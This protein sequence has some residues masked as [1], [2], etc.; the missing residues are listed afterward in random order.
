M[1]HRPFYIN[2]KLT[3]FQNKVL[4]RNLGI[5]PSTPNHVV[6]ALA[7]I[8]PT[9][10]RAQHLAEYFIKNPSSKTSIG[11]VYTKYQH[12]FDNIKIGNKICSSNKT[13]IKEDMF[14]VCKNEVSAE[15]LRAQYR[16]SINDL[17]AEG[18]SIWATDA[19]VS[20]SSTGCS[21]CN[22]YSGQNF[23]FRIEE[24]VSSLTGEL[25]AIEKAI[26]IILEDGISTAAIFTDSK[27]T[28]N[29]LQENSS[30]NCNVYNIIIKINKSN[31]QK[32][33][34]IWIPSHVG[35]LANE[36]A[37]YYA[38]HAAQVGC[39]TQYHTVFIKNCKIDL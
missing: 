7:S 21:V 8:L 23:L 2:K 15:Y 33:T 25:H 26:D 3:S 17:R 39:T 13:C 14:N 27:N 4:K 9:H 31:I 22:I 20:T 11:Y 30:R 12:I 18:I 6:C 10:L 28:C 34:F 5:V 35:I 36:T 29:L 38:K 19:S 24:K 32:V 1:A 37:D 16:K